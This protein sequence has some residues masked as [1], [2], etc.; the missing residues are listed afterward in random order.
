M[1]EGRV[2]QPGSDTEVYVGSSSSMTDM[3]SRVASAKG[4]DVFAACK[5]RTCLSRA[6]AD[7]MERFR[8]M[9]ELFKEWVP[10]DLVRAIQMRREVSMMMV[11]AP[12]IYAFFLFGRERA[13]RKA[14][15]KVW[16]RMS[17]ST[18]LQ[19]M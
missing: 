19:I 2:R 4:Q 18:R 7:S 15:L 6:P 17:P 8:L 14:I 13:W 3:A 12:G 9:A 5:R 1:Y 10:R 11:N 16:G